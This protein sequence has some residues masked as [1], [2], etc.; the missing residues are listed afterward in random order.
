MTPLFE[1]LARAGLAWFSIDY[2]LTPDVT[3][4]GCNSRTYGM[5]C[6]SSGRLHARFNIDPARIVP[7]RR[8]GQRSD[9][10][11]LLGVLRSVYSPVSFS[12]YGVLRFSGDGDGRCRRGRCWFACSR[13]QPALDD[14]SRQVLRRVLAAPTG[15]TRRCRRSCSSMAPASGCGRRRRRSRG[16]SRSSVSRHELIATRRRAAWLGELGRPPGVDDLQGAD[17][18]V[19]SSRRALT[20]GVPM[21]ARC[22]WRGP[23][24]APGSS[25]RR[26]RSA[27]C[28]RGPSSMVC[29][30]P[31]RFRAQPI[32]LRA[33]VPLPPVA[34]TR[35]P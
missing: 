25:R 10:D 22:V 14:D 28:P 6:A 4:R 35:S 32:V 26:P 18:R 1:L 27:P 15:R 33:L 17:D 20:P 9:G 21:P 12:F 11:A 24:H 16:G 30:E 29:A 23:P 3:S 34:K 13:G 7:P 8:V 2:R 19:D 31:D 5:R